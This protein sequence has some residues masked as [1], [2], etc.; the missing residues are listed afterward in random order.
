M[1]V[2]TGGEVDGE[3]DGLTALT[4]GPAL[5]VS[6]GRV[7]VRFG[8]NIKIRTRAT[9]AAKTSGR[10]ALPANSEGLGHSG[11]GRRG[12]C[13]DRAGSWYSSIVLDSN[14]PRADKVPCCVRNTVSPASDD[15]GATAATSR[16]ELR[17]WMSAGV[18]T[19][20]PIVLTPLTFL[21]IVPSFRR[22]QH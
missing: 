4:D 22:T 8:K 17:V 20:E 18:G 9:A 11:L 10:S 12:R 21:P 19:S 2:G 14:H 5:V 16:R 3:G 6:P 1:G 13:A 15:P 7:G